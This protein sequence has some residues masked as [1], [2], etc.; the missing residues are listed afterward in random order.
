[1]VFDDFS[2]VSETPIP[3]YTIGYEEV[4]S[5]FILYSQNLEDI[6]KYIGELAAR[7]FITL[8]LD[9]DMWNFAG[10]NRSPLLP[11]SPIC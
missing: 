9:D 11:G 10:G 4:V 8:S 5:V 1:M 7:R 2:Q 6:S 3:T